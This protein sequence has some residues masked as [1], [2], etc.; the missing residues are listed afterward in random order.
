MHG[1]IGHSRS[2]ISRLT[3]LKQNFPKLVLTGLVSGVLS[4]FFGIG[5]GFLV[6]PGRMRQR[7]WLGHCVWRGGRHSYAVSGLVDWRLAVRFFAGGMLA[8]FA[9]L[10][11]QAGSSAR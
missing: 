10:A 1:R 4:G 6:A 2:R 11:S 8:G 5:G 9:V 3:L 7:D